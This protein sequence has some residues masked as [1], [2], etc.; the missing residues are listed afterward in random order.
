ME[1]RFT[2]SHM[3]IYLP[4][5][6]ND[7]F[8]MKGYVRAIKLLGR[9]YKHKGEFTAFGATYECESREQFLNFDP[10]K[11]ERVHGVGLTFPGKYYTKMM[12]LANKHQSTETSD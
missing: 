1:Y 9:P 6:K 2:E 7:D 8:C 12:E 5:V 10:S 11:N 4:P 3:L